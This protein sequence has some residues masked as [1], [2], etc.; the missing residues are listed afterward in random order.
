M[1]ATRHDA[2]TARSRAAHPAGSAHAAPRRRAP[3]VAAGL[4]IGALGIVALGIGAPSL[5]DARPGSEDPDRPRAD[6]RREARGERRDAVASAL[7][8]EVEDLVAELRSGATIAQL[9]AERGVDIDTVVDAMLSGME[10]RLTER[11]ESGE[12]IGPRGPDHRRDH[13]RREAR[14]GA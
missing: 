8:M 7:G 4:G 6:E 12:P 10:E 14:W 5:A 11:L 1:D 2:R 13:P 9:A 3:L